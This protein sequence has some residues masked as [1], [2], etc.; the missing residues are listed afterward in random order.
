MPD[1]SAEW[2]VW[3]TTASVVVTDPRDLERAAQLTGDVLAEIDLAC[4]R[5]RD[6]SE[7]ARLRD[8]LPTGAIVSQTLADLINGAL[9]AAEW[10]DGAVDPT[11]G[12]DLIALGYDRDIRSIMRTNDPDAPADAAHG[13]PGAEPRIL[14]SR[15]PIAGWRRI[16]LRDRQLTVPADLTLDLGATAK[17][18]AADRAARQV[19]DELGCGV[20]VS[21]GG[22]IATAGPAPGGGWE[23]L[24]EDLP[25]DPWQQISL[26]AGFALA[27]SST[28]KRR[29]IHR[30]RYVHHILDPWLGLPAEPVWRS[31]TVAAPSCLR[32][33]A[34]STACVVRGHAAVD[35]LQ[36]EGVP[37]RFVDRAGRV[38][39]TASWP[40]PADEVS[41]GP[42]RQHEGRRGSDT[43]VPNRGGNDG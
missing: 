9:L 16:T 28:Q 29:W 14:P 18:L 24:V 15:N 41:A 4:S 38:V 7:L 10:S 3:G 31:V 2:P 40:V 33:N 19:V 37:A 43:G 22:D 26:A 34:L 11:L 13:G 5:F 32:A 8:S 35:W 6:D 23:V 36:R 20:L 12:N 1:L 25:S 42:P 17:A 39:T 27:T 30:G 21:L